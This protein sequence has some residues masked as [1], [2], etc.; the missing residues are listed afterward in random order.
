MLTKDVNSVGPSF[1]R[2][3]VTEIRKPDWFFH[4]YL[5]NN[6]LIS[7]ISLFSPFDWFLLKIILVDRRSDDIINNYLSVSLLYKT[8]R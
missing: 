2:Q 7:R 4:C 5:F 6:C 8:D 3:V 1:F